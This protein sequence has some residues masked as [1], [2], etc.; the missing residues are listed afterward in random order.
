MDEQKKAEK[1]EETTAPEGTGDGH[2]SESFD[3]VK[4]ATLAAER[5]EAANKKTE[6]LLIKQEALRARE[7][8][9]GKTEGPEPE[10][11]KKEISPADYA[12]LALQGAIE[13]A[14]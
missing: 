1:K 13:K 11:N 9:G 8:L 14:G 12:K 3:L 5:I 6:E 2:K 7:I 10:E 4:S